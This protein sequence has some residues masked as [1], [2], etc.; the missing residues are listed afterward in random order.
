MLNEGA[1]QRLILGNV[2]SCPARLK[3]KFLKFGGCK[4]G[5][6][7]YLGVA[8]DQLDGVQFRGVGWQ[9]VGAYTARAPEPGAD[10]ASVVGLQSIPDKLDWPAHRAR[11]CLHEG[12]D[13]LAVVIGVGQ[14]TERRA[15]AASLRRNDERP[16]HRDL[17]SRTTPLR[18]HGSLS[19]SR[20]RAPH[21]RCH[22]E[23]RFVE[24][25]EGR[26]PA[27][28]VF[29]TRGQSSLIQR[30][31]ATASRSTARRT[32]FCGLHPRPW[33]TRPI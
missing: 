18:E 19:A 2:E 24:E 32:G 22:Q 6:R 17:A 5:H 16:D 14:K 15:H 28:G 27:R 23:T 13:R 21:Q 26:F 11:E 31:M 3:K 10:R 33:S 1:Q 9:Q 8:P 20:P 29:F 12:E 30:A 25:D 7:V 4:I